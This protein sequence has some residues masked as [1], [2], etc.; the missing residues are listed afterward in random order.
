MPRA[1][2]ACL[3][4]ERRG[5]LSGDLNLVQSVASDAA[6]L[7]SIRVRSMVRESDFKVVGDIID[8]YVKLNFPDAYDAMHAAD[9]MPDDAYTLDDFS[10]DSM[11]EMIGKMRA[12]AGML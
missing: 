12:A 2:S 11:D 7:H 1:L 5:L 10:A 8:M 9:S 3:Q 6:H 4:A